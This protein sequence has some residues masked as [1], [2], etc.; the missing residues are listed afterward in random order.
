MQSEQS[1]SLAALLGL[2]I[3]SVASCIT[4]TPTSHNLLH[5][6]SHIILQLF[7]SQISTL[8]PIQCAILSLL[9]GSHS[10][11]FNAEHGTAYLTMSDG[12]ISTIEDSTTASS[13]PTLNRWKITHSLMSQ[14]ERT[15]SHPRDSYE[16]LNALPLDLIACS[17]TG[18][19]KLFG[20][21]FFY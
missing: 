15:S 14:H 3:F 13:P 7:N 12:E 9:V 18:S 19:G 17:P 5:L 20:S 4:D 6:P 16:W 1:P 21:V 8:F 2:P 11:F 10:F